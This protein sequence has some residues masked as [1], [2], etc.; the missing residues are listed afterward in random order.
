[1][2]QRCF[3]STAR[4]NHCALLDYRR[5]AEGTGRV[6]TLKPKPQS[7]FP[8]GQDVFIHPAGIPDADLPEWRVGWLGST[9]EFCEC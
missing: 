9:P 3:R 2:R 6:L 1:M 8:H 7:K 5:A 4:C